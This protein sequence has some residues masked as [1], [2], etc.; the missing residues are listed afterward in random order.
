MKKL[1]NKELIAKVGTVYEET[2]DDN[3]CAGSQIYLAFLFDKKQVQVSEI[4]VSSCDKET[5]HIIGTYTW[6]LLCTKEVKID[7]DPVTTEGTYAENIA[8]KIQDKQLIGTST[9]LN[10]QVI[11]YIFKEKK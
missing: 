8:L 6:K 11:E 4:E 9:H 7:F 2:P 10:G 3:P 1:L 5:L